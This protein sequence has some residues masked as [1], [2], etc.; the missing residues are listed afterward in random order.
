[1]C[2]FFTID[3]MFTVHRP[4]LSGVFWMFANVQLFIPTFSKM[5]SELLLFRFLYFCT[6]LLLHEYEAHV[7]IKSMTFCIEN[8]KDKNIATNKKIE[9][10][11]K[12]KFIWR[13]LLFEVDFCYSWGGFESFPAM[14]TLRIYACCYTWVLFHLI[15]CL[16]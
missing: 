13:F 14:W 10:K 1:M 16:C 6:V 2:F 3:F 4:Y 11:G 5:Q 7:R 8:I 9:T 12:Y 15:W